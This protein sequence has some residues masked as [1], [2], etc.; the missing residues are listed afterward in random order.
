VNTQ[1]LPLEG[2]LIAFFHQSSDLYGSDRI[3]LDLADGV[4]R[5][6]GKAVVLLPDT[7]PLTEEFAARNIEFHTLPVLKLSRS[8][9][10]LKGLFN[11]LLEMLNALSAY[12]H[13][14]GD[15]KV[16]IVHSNTLAVLGGA[17]WARRRRIPH[18]WHVHE[19]IEHPWIAAHVFP[20]LINAMADQVVCNSDATCQWLRDALPG[21]GKKMRV[22][23]NGVQ[24]P[25][26]SDEL[27]IAELQIKFR[28][29]GT[30]LAVGLVGRINRLKGHNL[31]MDAVELLH[32][33]G[34]DDFS[35][36]FIG[37]APPGQEVYQ[38]QLAERIARS[39]LRVRIVVQGF[40][41]NVW[42]IYAALDIVCVPST[43]PESFGLVAAEAMSMGK[44]VL[45]S[46]LGALSEVVVDGST[47]L[48]FDPKDTE[49]LAAALEKLLGDDAMRM[50]MGCAGKERIFAE[51]SVDT[52]LETFLSLYDSIIF[53]S[54]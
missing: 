1:R 20:R 4:Q 52:M 47:G 41:A 29:A 14:F 6:G 51:F 48:T 17:L 22:I 43:E 33:Q 34:V 32:R 38:S 24:S 35:V 40:T 10:G 45:A 37:S 3:L 7:G 26:C 46:R 11:L 23:R 53:N 44:P 31:L 2:K 5:A 13:V 54:Q 12:D 9:F 19:I 15:R 16:D 36:V 25:T 30:R 27:T 21:L 18:L 8:R 39:P 42:P 50:S 28:P 49:A